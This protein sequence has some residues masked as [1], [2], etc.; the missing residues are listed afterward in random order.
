RPDTRACGP[1]EIV[2][3]DR[4]ARL[5]VGKVGD[6]SVA[7]E[8][9]D[10]KLMNLRSAPHVVFRRLDLPAALRPHVNAPHDLAR[11]AWSFVLLENLH[12]ELHVL[13]EAGRRTHAKV[14]GVELETDVDDFF[15]R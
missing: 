4:F 8:E 3:G 7:V 1:L 5:L 12:L 13:L 2:L 10:R 15:D 14:L 9:P 6:D 11:P